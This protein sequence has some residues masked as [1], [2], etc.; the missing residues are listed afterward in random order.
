MTSNFIIGQLLKD[1]LKVGIGKVKEVIIMISDS[2]VI[3]GLY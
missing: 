3:I 2:V 1:L